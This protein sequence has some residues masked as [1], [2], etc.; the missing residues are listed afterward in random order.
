MAGEKYHNSKTGNDKH[1][2]LCSPG[3]CIKGSWRKNSQL[4]RYMAWQVKHF[5]CEASY[6]YFYLM[7][8]KGYC[9]PRHIS[10]KTIYLL[11]QWSPWFSWRYSS[12]PQM[13]LCIRQAL[14]RMHFTI[15]WMLNW[16]ICNLVFS[17][18]YPFVPLTSCNT[19]LISQIYISTF[20]HHEVNTFS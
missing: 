1:F 6:L 17:V 7:W 12:D 11:S 19:E 8:I 20:I 18:R 3:L 16:W 13:V 9:N 15:K 4:T 14:P 2:V 5:I 10:Q